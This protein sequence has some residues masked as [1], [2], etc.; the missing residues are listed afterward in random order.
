MIPVTSFYK[1]LQCQQWFLL[2]ISLSK[3]N[4]QDVANLYMQ[5]KTL[6]IYYQ[7]SHLS[8]PT[9]LASFFHD[10][11]CLFL[12]LMVTSSYQTPNCRR[13]LEN[14]RT[15]HCRSCRFHLFHEHWFWC[16][17]VYSG[18]NEMENQVSH[19]AQ[20]TTWRLLTMERILHN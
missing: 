11:P 10:S 8:Y 16:L 1:H 4:D 3:T 17:Y 9:A 19:N 2:P 7:K 20:T 12:K 5:M 6:I 13:C 18:Q 15:F 14:C